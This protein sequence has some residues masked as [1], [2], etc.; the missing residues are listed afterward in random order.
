MFKPVPVEITNDNNYSIE[1]HPVGIGVPLDEGAVFDPASL[2]LIFKRQPV[3]FNAT[4]LANWPDDSIKWLLLDFQANVDANDQSVYLLESD[5]SAD[6]YSGHALE[7]GSIVIHDVDGGCLVDTGPTRF[8]ISKKSLLPFDQVV[9]ENNEL[10]S[11]EPGYVQLLDRHGEQS[12]SIVTSV[13]YSDSDNRLTKSVTIAGFF[14]SGSE[15]HAEFKLK[16]IFYAGLPMVK[17][18]FTLLNP[19]A[20]KHPGGVWDLGDEGSFFFKELS[21]KIQLRQKE[22][23]YKSA[24]R[25]LPEADWR[26]AQNK[27]LTLEQNSS[28]GKNWKS[29]NHVNYAGKIPLA[30][31]GYRY[32]EQGVHVASGNRATPSVHLASGKTG[33]TAH[34]KDFWQNFP[35]SITIDNGVLQLGLFPRNDSNCYELQGGER[36]KHTFY[37][38]FS[39]NKVSLDHHINELIPR[40]PLEN[41]W[42]AKVVP[43]LLRAH[44]KTIMQQLI[45][46]GIEGEN[47]FFDKRESIDE[48]GWRNFGE[49]FAD[50]EQHEYKGKDELIS[51]YN[52]Q[53]DPLY[54]FIKQYFVSGDSRWYELL[55]Q[56]AQHIVDIDIYHTDKDR[57]EYN[58]GLFWHTH[59]YLSAFTCTH[60]TFSCRHEKDFLYG[61]TGGGPGDEHCYTTGLSYYYYMTGDEVYKDAALQLVNWIS[62][63]LEGS[64]TVAEK[65]FQFKRKDLPILKRL[66]SGETIQRYKYPF[67]RGTGNYITA[68]ID[69][70][71]L[72][73]ERHYLLRVEK[74]IYQ[75]IHPYDDISLR[76]L[77]DTEASWSYLIYLQAVCKYLDL[78]TSLH[79]VDEASVYARDSLLHYVDWMLDNESPFLNH[80]E[81]LEYPNHTWTAQDLRK[82]SLFYVASLYS[83]DKKSVYLDTAHFYVRYVEET[84]LN[85]D[86]RH[87]SRILI[88]LM[89]NYI[90]QPSLDYDAARPLRD[91]TNTIPYSPEPL[92]TISGLLVG[93]LREFCIRVLKLSFKNE[94][95]W[96]SFRLK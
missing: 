60:R 80:A 57:D 88:L 78:K 15:S 71:N 34:I 91:S 82:A 66:I 20:A 23:N 85:E 84:L 13:S 48:Y 70:F 95:R 7:A 16:L 61:K 19:E 38:D 64:G 11:D 83:C 55:S 68:L 74:V 43:W 81:R 6:K 87:Y 41:Y 46:R 65:L 25:L 5:A 18:E 67:T 8:R 30:Y 69:A 27:S 73:G 14:Q 31:K 63:V 72:T 75:S 94:K 51:H 59:H 33:I 79:E 93:A 28:G 9:H 40:I 4:P 37:L 10:L 36:K 86:T 44:E 53:Y 3:Q 58:G 1:N 77:E 17:C 54:G 89:Q 50:H 76:N 24:I 2:Q 56:L 96:L 90:H 21:I 62:R 32:F 47:N 45:D 35:K 39:N 29:S 49:I 42:A 12:N 26:F 52:N 92:Y 22:D